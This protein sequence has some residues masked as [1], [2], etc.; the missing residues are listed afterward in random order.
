MA[1]AILGTCF[2][3]DRPTVAGCVTASTRL[4]CALSIATIWKPRVTAPIWI[5]SR[6]DDHENAD[7]ADWCGCDGRRPS[8]RWPGARLYSLARQQLH[9][10]LSAMGLLW[11]VNGWCRQG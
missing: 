3:M 8:L 1:T 5:R 2:P 11:R 7:D 9:A 4:R 10:Q 6:A